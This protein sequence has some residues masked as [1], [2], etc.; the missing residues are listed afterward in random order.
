MKLI[1]LVLWILPFFA[2]AQSDTIR[3]NRDTTVVLSVQPTIEPLPLDDERTTDVLDH[4]NVFY[5]GAVN[6]NYASGNASRML[7]NTTHSLNVSF[8]KL[9]FPVQASFSYGEQNELL[10]EREYNVIATPSVRVNKWRTYTNFE[11]EKSQLR[12]VSDRKLYGVGA[13]YVFY[14][15]SVSN[16]LLVSNLLLHERSLYVNG[17]DRVVY[18][19][20]TR[21]RLRVGNKKLSG[22]NITFY[23][24]SIQDVSNYRVTSKLIV[25]YQV[26]RKLAFAATYNYTYESVLFVKNTTNTNTALTFGLVFTEK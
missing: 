25:A 11:Y 17:A 16:Q 8:H 22:D 21:L 13:G 10:K 2:H 5:T 26:T 7:V 12:G 1:L 23:Q 9:S 6:G 24:P 19:N 20:S 4:I 15:D 3:I 14:S 18:R